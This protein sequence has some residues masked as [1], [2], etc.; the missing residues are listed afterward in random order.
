MN[1]CVRVYARVYMI[2]WANE[3][4]EVFVSTSECEYLTVLICVFEV[5]IEKP[6]RHILPNKP[7]AMVTSC[8]YVELEP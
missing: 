1:E 2:V 6:N 8:F 4:M 5:G 7:V 3:T